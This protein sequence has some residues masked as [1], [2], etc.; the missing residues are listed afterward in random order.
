[1]D[2]YLE[3]MQVRRQLAAVTRALEDYQSAYDRE[4]ALH[5]IDVRHKDETIESCEATIQRLSQA[6]EV[7]RTVADED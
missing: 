2:T 3:L 6:L 7:A 1:M 5:E 4:K